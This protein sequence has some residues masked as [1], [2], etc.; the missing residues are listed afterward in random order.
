[1][2]VLFLGGTSYL[3]QGLI[4]RLKFLGGF[5]ITIVKRETPLE[6]LAGYP[7]QEI[8]FNLVVDYGRCNQ[9]LDELI[10][11]N[12]D[13][14]FERIKRLKFKTL[15]NFS[16]ALEKEV[17]PYAH[18]KK[19][20]EEKLFTEFRGSNQQIFN[21]HLQHF[22]G[23]GAPEHNF[24]TFLLGKLRKNEPIELT[25]GQQKRDFIFIDDVVDAI[26][27]LITRCNDLRAQETIQ[28]GSAVSVRMEDIIRE[29]KHLT[30][31][32]SEL[33]FG[34][35]PRRANEPDELKADISLLKGLGWEPRGNW[36]E[37]IT[38]IINK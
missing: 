18:S 36:K 3:G 29:L 11:I 12:V 14:P 8:V 37:S 38:K 30:K 33:L 20:L 4:H 9:S 13:F 16:T 35:I 23:P 10:K 28:I 31:S 25:D 34:A 26:V 32:S 27:L 5:E 2:K 17:S 7:E 6:E 19:M 22:Y 1:M 15:M 21:L 24:V